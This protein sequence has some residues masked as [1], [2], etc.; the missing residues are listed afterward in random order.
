MIN[1]NDG[2]FLLTRSVQQGTVIQA[3]VPARARPL[4]EL[5]GRGAAGVVERAAIYF[6]KSGPESKNGATHRHLLPAP[7]RK[8]EMK[9]R[10][11][12]PNHLSPFLGGEGQNPLTMRLHAREGFSHPYSPPFKVGAIRNF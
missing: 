2:V 8:N 1:L 4:G 9:L 6:R 11:N 3:E 7:C 12:P 10:N 5:A